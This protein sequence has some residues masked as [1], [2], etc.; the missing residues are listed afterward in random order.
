MRQKKP[1]PYIN[2]ELSWLDFNARVLEEALNPDNP[3]LEQKKF[4]S[5]Y[6]SNIDEFYMVRVG[7]LLDQSLSDHDFVD[8]ISGM[9]SYDQLSAI[10]AKTA[11]MDKVYV[12]ALESV[13]D[14]LAEHN[15]K[16]IRPEDLNDQEEL[17]RQ[18]EAR[19]MPVLSPFVL[20]GKHPFPY[21]GNNAL[22]CGVKL[23]TKTEK[24]RTGIVLFPNNIDMV[25]FLNSKENEIRFA[26]FEEIVQ[27][28]IEQLFARYTVLESATFKVIRN[29]D[30]IL[31]DEALSDEIDYKQAMVEILKK[32][33]WLTPVRLMTTAAKGSELVS[34][35]AGALAIKQEQSFYGYPHLYTGLAWD[36]IPAA[37][38]KNFSN[39]MFKK[40]DRVYPRSLVRGQS[41]IRQVQIKDHLLFHPFERFEAVIELLYEAARDPDVIS[42]KQT[43]YR[44]SKNSAIVRALAEASEI[45]KEVTVLV[46]LKARFDEE[47][48]LN[49]ATVLEESGC[50]VIYGKDNLKVHSKCTLI[51]RKTGRGFSYISHIGTGNYNENTAKLYTDLG[52]L[53]AN[54]LIAEDLITFFNDLT[55]A[56]AHPYH[57]LVVSPDGIRE[58]VYE[59]IDKEIFNA[60]H[61]IRAHIVAKLN[62]IADKG[63]VDKLIQASQAGV[64]IQ[65]IVRGICCVNAGLPG[66]T[67]NIE[68]KSIVGRFLEHSRIFWFYNS[69]QEKFQISSAD[70][71]TRNLDRRMEIACPVEDR[72]IKAQLKHILDVLLSDCGKGRYMQPDGSYVHILP[73]ENSV[74]DSQMALYNEIAAETLSEAEMYAATGTNGAFKKII[75]GGL[76]RWADKIDPQKL[77]P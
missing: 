42:I 33:R 60:R 2:R 13:F 53:T 29:A 20:D 48:N 46:E 14:S 77:T 31:D 45:G 58:S 67:E 59:M 65:L 6:S 40:I 39:L 36:L 5:I 72:R 70:W 26:L 41:I 56:E 25:I 52:L 37:Q 69:G 4:L 68:V 75:A 16:H 19:I 23:L 57:K 66:F 55:G 64:K 1:S 10:Y 44:V 22:F 54:S 34:S 9:S 74:K 27:Y 47:N 11:E 35:V 24:E 15:I 38:E 30:L 62:S 32:R 21:I 76:R 3:P 28:F 8:P 49:Y 43:L 7:S 71:M 73:D 50:R 63:M 51:T 12:S 18:F 61:G 17:Q